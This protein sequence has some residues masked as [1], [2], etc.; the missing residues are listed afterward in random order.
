MGINTEK[1]RVEGLRD[2]SLYGQRAE[3]DEQGRERERERERLKGEE[4]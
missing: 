3:G 2:G 1:R 4:D